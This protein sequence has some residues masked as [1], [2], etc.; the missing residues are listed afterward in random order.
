MEQARSFILPYSFAT[1]TQVNYVKKAVFWVFFSQLYVLF[2][3]LALFL[4]GTENQRK[5]SV[6]VVYYKVT[7]NLKNIFWRNTSFFVLTLFLVF[8][9]AAW[10]QDYTQEK[11]QIQESVCITAQF[12]T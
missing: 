11:T 12:C 1:H 7:V 4:V 2:P 10:K 5:I 8:C 6:Y 3:Y 9:W